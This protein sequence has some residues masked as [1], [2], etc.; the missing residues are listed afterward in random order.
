LDRIAKGLPALDGLAI[1]VKFLPALTAHKGK[2]ESGSGRGTEVHAA[3]FPRGRIMVL[4]SAL[5]KDNEELARIFVHE[6]F[7]F[8]WLRLGNARRWE[9]EKLIHGDRA[10]LGWSSELRLNRLAASDRKRRTKRW[11]TYA[12]ESF[13]DTAAYLFSGTKR[14]DEYRL[15]AAQRRKRAA[16]FATAVANRTILV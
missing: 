12:C 14:H 2:M 15:P 9:Y 6:L 4:D 13:C 3:T 16:W 5:L 1:E 11:R 10:E 8:V 7:H